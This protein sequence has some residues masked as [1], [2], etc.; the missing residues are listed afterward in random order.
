MRKF[1]GSAVSASLVA[2]SCALL[3]TAAYADTPRPGWGKTHHA[4]PWLAP[5][6]QTTK[7][8]VT[9][10][11][12][13]AIATFPGSNGPDTALLLM[14]G[15]VIM[16][17]LC[18]SNWYRL[19]PDSKGNYTT[20]TWSNIASMQSTYTPLY[21]A[22]QVLPNGNVIVNGGE[23][24]TGCNDDHTTMGAIYNFKTNK[25]KSVSPPNG[26]GQIGDASSIVLQSGK[27]MLSDCCNESDAI[28][29]ISKKLGV[30]WTST[31]TGK[32]DDNNE[33]GWTLLSTGNVLAVDVWK[34]ARQNSAAELY[35]PT[36][37]SWSATGTATN[38]MA[39][40]SSFELGPALRL[41]N[42]TVFQI[43]TTPCA[44]STCPS[45]TSIYNV[46]TGTW[47]AGP[48][49]LKVGGNY[50][51]TEDAPAAVLPDGNVLSQQSPSY[52]CGQSGGPFCSPSHFFEFDGT[53]WTQ[54][55]DPA[56][57][58]SDASYEGRLLPLPTGQVLWSS[59]QGDVEIYTP[60]GSPNAAWLPTIASVGTVTHGMAAS[61][62]GTQLTGVS[63]GGKYGD[64]A[65]MAS[66]YP[67]IRITNNSTG[68]V[69]FG[70]TKKFSATSA[71]FKV[72]STCE[73]GASELTATV[74]GIASDPFAVTVN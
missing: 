45:H 8:P 61:L 71:N 65:Q 39:D 36:T 34:T 7:A 41:P 37:G 27:Y 51:T 32:A 4:G 16:H 10:G 38:V 64:D 56:Q 28:A 6:H 44:A 21:F 14:D 53:S 52:T 59:D 58:P 13:T 1:H 29:K 70:V 74:N 57:A 47:T 63:D 26:W 42:G 33:E 19:T 12:W 2:L 43:G 15:T 62:T 23:Y 31:G 67:I 11:T 72:P 24:N 54:V 50:Y 5:Y 69:C 9:S 25:W 73:T 68:D 35:N 20:G 60:V 17:D 55:N 30:A 40:P 66:N 46:S 22:S 48:D 3:A 18:T 49:E